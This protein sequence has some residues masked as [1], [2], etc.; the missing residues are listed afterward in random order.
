MTNKKINDVTFEYIKKAYKEKVPI[1]EIMARTDLSKTSIYNVLKTDE[2]TKYR[3]VKAKTEEFYESIKETV[4]KDYNNPKI[5]TADICKKNK[6]T[7]SQLKN[8]TS[9][10]N[11]PMRRSVE[12]KDKYVKKN[13]SEI[14]INTLF[15]YK[16]IIKDYKKGLTVLNIMARHNINQ[17]ALYKLL[18]RN[19]MKKRGRGIANSNRKHIDVIIEEY[20]NTTD[21]NTCF[22]KKMSKKYSL[23]QETIR[24]WLKEK[25]VYAY[26]K[27]TIEKKYNLKRFSVSTEMIE[28]LNDYKNQKENGYKGIIWLTLKYN[29]C[30]NTIRKKLQKCGVLENK[31]LK[32]IE[33]NLDSLLKDYQENVING[34]PDIKGLALKYKCSYNKIRKLLIKNSVYQYKFRRLERKK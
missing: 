2:K 14:D 32:F 3:E 18:K 15:D 20:S 16:S 5:T 24:R 17:E 11:V 25:E 29:C 23:N 6:I 19:N 7:F 22:L 10:Y 30:E 28:L 26:K 4:I 34:K 27:K 21:S 33:N 8:L 1:L 31:R 12:Y 9:I 13:K